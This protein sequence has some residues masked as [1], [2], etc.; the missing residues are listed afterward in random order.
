MTEVFEGGADPNASNGA[1]GGAALDLS[2]RDAAGLAHRVREGDCLKLMR[3]MEAE[4]VDLVL[5]DPPYHA[6]KKRNI[7][8]DADFADDASYL[9]WMDSLGAEWTRVLKPSGSLFVFCHPSLAGRIECVLSKRFHILNHLVW[10]KPDEPGFDGWGRKTRKESL[11]SW[12]NRSERIIFAE[13]FHPA[14]PGRPYFAGLLR[15]AR[16]ASGMSAHA[17]TGAIGAHGRVN[18]GGAVSN[19]EAGRNA[20]SAEQWERLRAVL[21]SL[22]PYGEAVRPFSLSAGAAYEDVFAHRPVRPHR[23]KHPAEKP[24]GMLRELIEVTTPKGGAVLDCFGGS[25][26]TAVAAASCGR[27]SVTFEVERAWAERTL[28]RLR[29][30]AGAEGGAAPAD[31]P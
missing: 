28:G 15:E 22:P 8:G 3:E 21:T 10:T 29:E 31:S 30:A 16:T 25:G 14:A 17:L 1:K 9:E 5:T 6:T 19:W 27:A 13:R 26:S 23:G 11:R 2:V 7:R 18:H 4:S 20:P 24:V 12:F